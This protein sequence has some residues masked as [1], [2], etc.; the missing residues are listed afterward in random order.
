VAVRVL[1]DGLGCAR[2]PKADQERLRGAG[3][4]VEVFRS[5]R[6]GKFTRFHKRDHRRAIVVDGTLGFTGGSAIGD[7]WLGDAANEDEWRDFMV[8]VTGPL[9]ATL[10]SAFVALWANSTGEILSGPSVFPPLADAV[11]KAGEEV[12]SHMGVASSPSAENHPGDASIS[13]RPT[14]CCRASPA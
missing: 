5:A 10:Q 8:E 11:G 2:A 6:L 4:Q 14:S 3:G 12:T 1:L 7:K 9:A 13:R